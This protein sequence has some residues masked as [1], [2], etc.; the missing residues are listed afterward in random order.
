M[1]ILVRCCFNIKLLLWIRKILPFLCN[2]SSRSL[3]FPNMQEVSLLCS[4]I[5]IFIPCVVPVSF[6]PKPY[7]SSPSAVPRCCSHTEEPRRGRLR[8]SLSVSLTRFCCQCCTPRAKEPGFVFTSSLFCCCAPIRKAQQSC[9][10]PWPLHAPIH[11]EKLIAGIF[12]T[13]NVMIK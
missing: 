4:I 2:K 12:L 3:C 11:R 13:R 6:V 1:I 10:H 8:P 9:T 5:N 7:K